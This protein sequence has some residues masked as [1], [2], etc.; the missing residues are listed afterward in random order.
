MLYSEFISESQQNLLELL[1]CCK[2]LDELSSSSICQ[3]LQY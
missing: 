2:E 1:D 3:S